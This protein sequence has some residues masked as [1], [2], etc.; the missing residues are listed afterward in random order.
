MELSEH[1]AALYAAYEELL[2][3]RQFEILWLHDVEALSG[4]EI[5]YKLGISQ[6]AASRHLNKAKQKLKSLHEEMIAQSHL[7]E[8][9]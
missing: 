1:F 6:S 5:A 2:T 3:P 9:T 8:E 7:P 4:K